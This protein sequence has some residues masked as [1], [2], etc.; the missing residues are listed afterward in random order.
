MDT[1]IYIALSKE[2]GIFRDMEVTANNIANVN[3]TGYREEKLLFE[4]FLVSANKQEGKA[5]FANDVATFRNTQQGTLQ[6]TNAPLDAAISGEGYFV[7][8][9]PLGPRYTRNGSFKIGPDGTL[10]TAQGH[11]VL[12]DGDQPILF[13]DADRE[14]QF[15]ENGAINVDGAERAVI[16]VVQFANPQMLRGVGEGMYAAEATPEPGAEGSFRVLG[17]VLER[18]NVNPFT[19][20]THMLHVSRSITNVTNFIN[21]MY[22]LERKASDT[23]VKA[24]S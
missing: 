17:G 10:V 4:D 12:D 6:A 24:Y 8:Q 13:D 11:A 19:A 22:T 2:I 9:T 3:T 23:L 20:L 7:V 18:S 5:A 21:T 15:R 14:I 1:S 16:Q